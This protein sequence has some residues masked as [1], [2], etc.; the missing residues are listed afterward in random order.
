ML[1]VVEAGVAAGVLK[2]NKE[3]SIV[4]PAQPL[5]DPETGKMNERIM[6]D[7]QGNPND[8][9]I[10]KP[11]GGTVYITRDLAAIRYRREELGADQIL[12]VVGK[13]QKR[14]FKILFAMAEQLGYIERGQARHLDFGHLNVDGKKM[15]SRSGLFVLLDAILDD[16]IA[17]AEE[18]I[19]E[20]KTEDGEAGE[21]TPEERETARRVG[22]AAVEFND[23]RQDRRTD[24]E[25]SPEAAK[26]FESGGSPYIQYTYA[27]L[28]S[29]E[30]KAATKSTA[31]TAKL[32]KELP[33]DMSSGDRAVLRRLAEYPETI[34]EASE[35][36][37]P[38]RVGMYLTEL[39]KDLNSFYRDSPVLSSKGAVREFRLALVA[40]ARQ[41]FE[42]GAE[43]LHIELPERM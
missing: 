4:F 42:N 38:H 8:E 39:A 10:L 36:N 6:D 22:I 5:F 32:P 26:T 37:A 27:R 40:A 3:G 19:L 9:V 12:Y 24:I 14:H 35:K 34:S 15:K 1:A 33:A 20:R 11:S 17:A 21:L 43:Q 2:K 30:R 29:I 7:K 18:L 31:E 41:V 16:S 13:E 25:Y 28:R 23:L